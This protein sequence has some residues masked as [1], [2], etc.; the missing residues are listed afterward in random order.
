MLILPVTSARYFRWACPDE[1]RD[2]DGKLTVYPPAAPLRSLGEPRPAGR[3]KAGLCPF[4]WDSHGE[5]SEA[6]LSSDMSMRICLS[7]LSSL[8]SA[9]S[10]AESSLLCVRVFKVDR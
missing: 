6:E 9:A 2:K 7:R 10:I 5:P 4:T 3:S 1:G 8:D